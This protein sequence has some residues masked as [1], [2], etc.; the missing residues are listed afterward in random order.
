VGSGTYRIQLDS[1]NFS[2]GF[3]G[4]YWL[5][6]TQ[7]LTPTS[8]L[9]QTAQALF[10]IP[11]VDLS[12]IIAYLWIWAGFAMVIIGAGLASLNR[13]VLEAARIDGATEWQTG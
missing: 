1:S 10:S 9:S 8:G 5:S 12:M 6:G 13:E 4:I 7:S 11:L 2:S 3:T